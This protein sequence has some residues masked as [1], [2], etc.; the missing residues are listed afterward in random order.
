MKR[1]GK[2][3][4]LLLAA[5]TLLL[6][7]CGALGG[8]FGS[9]DNTEEYRN[10]LTSITGRWVL[11][12]DESTYFTFDGAKGAMT[13]RYVEGGTEKYSGSF[14]ALYRG[15]GAK[16]ATP[17]DLMLTRTDKTAED[18]LSC[19]VED[20]DTDFTQF[21]VMA[22]EEDLGFT[23]GT[24]YTHIYR[25]SELPYQMGTYVLEGKEKK[26]E[27]DNYSEADARHIPAGTYTAEGGET[28]TFL[29]TKPTARELFRYQN[30]D[31][32]MEGT[33][34]MAADG[35]TIYLYIT[36][37]PYSKVTRADKE[38]YDTTFDIYYPP[39]FYLR[40]DFTTAGQLVIDGLYHHPESPTEIEDATF[41]FGTYVS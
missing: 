37:D 6:C 28:F 20:F 18:W 31:T 38:H 33:F 22:E 13:F 7:G 12:G 41:V 29:M 26:A 34:W 39:D 3:A 8:L 23:D 25:I 15:N 5:L 19:Y 35:K 16:I 2:I 9:G 11:E 4:A 14:R 40:G 36:H 27:S 30:G 10:E 32:V 21:T 17:L 1:Y 24:V